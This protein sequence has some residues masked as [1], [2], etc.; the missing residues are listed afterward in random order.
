MRL[1]SK[2]LFPDEK[3]LVTYFVERPASGAKEMDFPSISDVQV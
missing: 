2:K 1:F 3:E